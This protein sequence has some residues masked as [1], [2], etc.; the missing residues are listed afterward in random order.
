[1]SAVFGERLFAIQP[2]RIDDRKIVETEQACVV[3]LARVGVLVKR[4][5]RHTEDVTFGPVEPPAVLFRRGSLDVLDGPRVATIFVMW[6]RRMS[7]A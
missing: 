7:S 1:M 6:V 3:G 2:E 4:P 5:G